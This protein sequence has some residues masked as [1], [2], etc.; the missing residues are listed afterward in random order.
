MQYEEKHPIFNKQQRSPFWELVNARNNAVHVHPELGIDPSRAVCLQLGSSRP[1]CL[2][3]K[4]AL[5]VSHAAKQCLHC[6][7]AVS[8]QLSHGSGRESHREVGRVHPSVCDRNDQTAFNNRRQNALAPPSLRAA[9]GTASLGRGQPREPAPYERD[10]FILASTARSQTTQSTT[11][12]MIARGDSGRRSYVLTRASKAAP[13]PSSK[14]SEIPLNFGFSSAP[15][16]Y[17]TSKV[18]SC[19]ISQ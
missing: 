18:E 5:G 16:L 1:S 4:R 3:R 2:A 6:A 15:E 17:R 14:S 19:A 7:R 9:C 12:S 13:V 10:R 11:G 8:N